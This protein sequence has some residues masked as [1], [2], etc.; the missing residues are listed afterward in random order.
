MTP[1]GQQI[2]KEEIV[3]SLYPNSIGFG[4]AVMTSALTV[5]NSRVVQVRPISNT[6][7][8]KRIREII[9]Y[10][11]PKIVVLEDC[12]IT[13]SRK[14]KRIKKMINTISRYALKKHLKIGTYSRADIRYVFSSFNARTKYEIAQVISENIKNMKYK[15]MKPRKTSESEKYMAGAFD[16]V[17]LGITHFYMDN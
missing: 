10:Y 16:A 6:H 3:L 7:T 5:L 15:L 14:S 11:E 2:K 8:M 13:G 9:D 4:F 12:S 1:S 17:S